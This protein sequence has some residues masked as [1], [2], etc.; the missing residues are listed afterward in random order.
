LDVD[1][2][3]EGPL[4]LWAVHGPEAFLVVVFV[5]VV[6]VEAVASFSCLV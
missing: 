4:L 3:L 6:V 5:V 1:A 2:S